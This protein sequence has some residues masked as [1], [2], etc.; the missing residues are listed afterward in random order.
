LVRP[1]QFDRICL[2]A[3]VGDEIRAAIV[4][5]AKAAYEGPN[6]VT[7]VL[8][9]PGLDSPPANGSVPGGLSPMSGAT[10]ATIDAGEGPF[11]GRNFL[12]NWYGPKL[13]ETITTAGSY[14]IR[15]FSPSDWHGEYILTTTGD[16][17]DSASGNLEDTQLPVPGDADGDGNVTIEDAI[18][19]L[20]VALGASIIP[21]TFTL[22]AADVAPPGTPDRFLLPG[23]GIINLADT[24]RILRR[25][26][27]L[28]NSPDWPDDVSLE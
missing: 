4:I 10:F 25:V 22:T 7:M 6:D 5:P 23:D 14:E 3:S 26:A 17:P 21:N 27:G 18:A 8:V 15:V 28:D 19:A 2:N 12:G 13:D 9:G 16:D 24:V 11:P 1:G 20:Q